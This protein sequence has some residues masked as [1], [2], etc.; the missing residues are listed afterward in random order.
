MEKLIELLNEYELEKDNY[1]GVISEEDIYYYSVLYISKQFW[2]IK[3][4]V[5]NE[6]VNPYDPSYNV[7]THIALWVDDWDGDFMVYERFFKEEELLMLLSI[8][9]EPINFLVSILK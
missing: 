5:E 4:L 1:S 7:P 8:Q 3:W 6:K 9:D 2:F